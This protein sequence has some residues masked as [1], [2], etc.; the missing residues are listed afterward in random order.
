MIKKQK[1]EIKKGYDKNVLSD[2]LKN[3]EK[4]GILDAEVGRNKIKKFTIIN[5]G[6]K[7]EI[8]VKNF[9]KKNILS[10]LIY[11]YFTASK[12]KR[13]YEYANRLLEKNIKT[14]EPI[15]YFDDYIDEETKEKKE[16]LYK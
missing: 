6:E 16:F 15:A 12:A 14:P 2:I 3:F 11:K 8:N 4:S 7:K 5:N 13:S 9:G 10:Q 1:Y